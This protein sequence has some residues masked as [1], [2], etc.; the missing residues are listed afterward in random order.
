MHLRKKKTL[1]DQASDYVESVR[2]QVEAAVSQALDAVEEF[3]EST[4]KPAL[5]DAKEKTSAVTSD[6]KAKAVPLAAAGAALAAERAHS[7]KELAGEKVARLKGE[8]PK[9][10]HKLRNLLVLLGLAGVAAFVAKKFTG[11]SADN[12]QSTYTPAPP[13][14]APAPTDVTD[15]V[16]GAGPDEAL[17]DTVEAPHPTSTPDSPAEVIDVEP[18]RDTG[19]RP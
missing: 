4:A 2:P 18:P 3:V 19:P 10:S 15:D 5:A 16:G 1:L 11:G 9:E 13:P 6:A 14:P 7:A 12:W 8:K 17:S